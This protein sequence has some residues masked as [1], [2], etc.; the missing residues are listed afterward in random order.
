MKRSGWIRLTKKRRLKATS[1]ELEPAP[2]IKYIIFEINKLF[3]RVRV[4]GVVC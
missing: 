2:T 1:T 4:V 3:K